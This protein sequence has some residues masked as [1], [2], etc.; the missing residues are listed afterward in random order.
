MQEEIR[1]RSKTGN[2][3]HHSV[4]SLLSSRLLPKII[5]IK[6]Y[7]S[8]LLPFVL[9]RCETWLLTLREEHR[10]RVFENRAL[11]RIF[12]S[13]KNEVTGGWRKLQNEELSDTYSSPNIVRV[14]KSRGMSRAGHVARMWERRGFWWGNLREGDHLEDSGVDG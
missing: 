3:C 2:A 11:R 9:Y 12:G 1:S 14:I 8:I 7:K 4:Q 6:I 5:K 10:L 13:G